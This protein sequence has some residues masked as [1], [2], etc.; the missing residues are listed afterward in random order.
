MLM[1]N[2]GSL[3]IASMVVGGSLCLHF[4]MTNW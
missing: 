3:T 2:E 1:W 4:G